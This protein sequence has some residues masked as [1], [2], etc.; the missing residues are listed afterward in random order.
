MPWVSSRIANEILDR[1]T[2][3]CEIR[4]HIKDG[5]LSDPMEIIERCLAVEK[6]TVAW[7]AARS[8]Y[9]DHTTTFV[10]PG[11]PFYSQEDIYDGHFAVYSALWIAGTWNIYRSTRIFIHEAILTQ[12]DI[13]LTQSQ[14]AEAAMNLLSQRAR[15]L[16]VIHETAADVCASIPY[17]LNHH[18]TR[19]EQ[20]ED[21]PRAAAGYFVL[22]SLY[23]AGSTIGVPHAMR[24]YALSRL[25]YIGYRMG[26]GQAL[27]LAKI[28]A[29]KI[30]ESGRSGGVGSQEIQG[31]PRQVGFTDIEG[32]IKWEDGTSTEVEPVFSPVEDED[33]VMDEDVFGRY[34]QI[35]S[36]DPRSPI[37]SVGSF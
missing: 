32:Q 28:L 12:V 3:L 19:T 9:W 17:L 20:T 34:A 18:K 22:T 10:V 25:R 23:L 7:A 36:K 6:L 8:T 26:L 11:D 15:S 37:D 1:I 33:E 29:G 27:L 31:V 16:A 5:T 2:D 24:L 14:S 4:A 35:I 30:E 13:L 21:P